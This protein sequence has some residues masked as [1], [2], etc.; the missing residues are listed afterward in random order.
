M[1][2]TECGCRYGERLGAPENRTCVADRNAEPLMQV[3]PNP[4]DSAC[5]NLSCIPKAWVFDVYDDCWIIQ[6]KKET[7]Q[8]SL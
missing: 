1:L 4:W 8:A 7:V 5:R 3:C 2:Q 6:A